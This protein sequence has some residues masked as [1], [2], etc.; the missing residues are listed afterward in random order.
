[1]PQIIIKGTRGPVL[2]S[3]RRR[4]DPSRGVVV[5]EE[6]ASAGDNLGGLRVAAEADFR[7]TEISPHPVRSRLLISSSG[8]AAGYG[9][10]VTDTWQL[11]ANQIS[12]D[13]K[14]HPSVIQMEIDNP[15]S[16]AAT[17][18]AV[19][20]AKDNGE[21]IAIDPPFDELDT[22]NQL[23]VLMLHGIASYVVDQ[24]AL[25]HTLNVPFRYGGGIGVSSALPAA[26]VSVLGEIAI[27]GPNDGTL[28]KW[29]W[30]RTGYQYTVGANNRVELNTE[31]ALASWALLLYPASS[32]TI[33]PS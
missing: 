3:I 15:G 32:I 21:E 25:R 29:G 20:D 23:A 4:W 12:R 18:K 14:E 24:H 33:S 8:A 1:M 31:W 30:R 2:Q 7:D 28:F 13:V 6:Y 9:N 16:L 11:I 22:A 26:M 5:T 19:Q 10:D 27:N 17:I